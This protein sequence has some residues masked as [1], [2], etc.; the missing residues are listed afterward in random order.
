MPGLE[1]SRYVEWFV[2]R[3]PGLG[4]RLHS[5]AAKMF[6]CLLNALPDRIIKI[7]CTGHIRDAGACRSDTDR[8]EERRVR[9]SGLKRFDYRRIN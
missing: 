6:T 9:A 4:E 2:D 8:E 7:V 5:V 3:S 1:Y